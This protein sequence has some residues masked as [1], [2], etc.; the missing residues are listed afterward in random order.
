M[1]YVHFSDD[2]LSALV[3]ATPKQKPNEKVC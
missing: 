2:D 3:E 1:G